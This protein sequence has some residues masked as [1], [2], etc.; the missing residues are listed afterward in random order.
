MNVIHRRSNIICA[1]L[2]AGVLGSSSALNTL[3]T[4][5]QLPVS[6][7]SSWFISCSSEWKCWGHGSPVQQRDAQVHGLV[8]ST[9]APE[10]VGLIL[11]QLSTKLEQTG[12]LESQ[13][14]WA[15]EPG[16]SAPAVLLESY[17]WAISVRA[18]LPVWMCWHAQSDGTGSVL[19]AWCGCGI[20]N[21]LHYVEVTGSLVKTAVRCRCQPFL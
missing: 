2:S 10:P 6:A 9:P 11:P 7:Y 3:K 21:R 17:S 5:R 18:W 8:V 4:R 12:P 13:A 14:R 15:Q 16:C 20:R 19:L 1:A